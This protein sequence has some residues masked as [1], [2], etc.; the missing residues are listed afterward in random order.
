M[1]PLTVAGFA[2]VLA[3]CPT[4]EE[5]VRNLR[6]Q[7]D[8]VARGLDLAFFRYD[9]RRQ[10]VVERLKEVNGSVAHDPLELSLDHLPPKLK[11]EVLLGGSLV[12][13]G[14]QSA[15][16]LK[17]FGLGNSVEG[18]LLLQAVRFDGEPW[19]L[20]AV[21]EPRQR[22]GS[23]VA[24]RIGAPIGVF[25]LA[26]T[27]YAEREAR[28]HAEESLETLLG[29]VHEEYS[30]SLADLR[31]ALAQAQAHMTASGAGA[32]VAELERAARAAAEQ[33]RGAQARLAA[34]E[35]QVSA[36][37]TQLEKAH[38]DLS[39]QSD[40]LRANGAVFQEIEQALAGSAVGEDPRRMLEKVRA[41]VSAK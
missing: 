15:D 14:D 1:P 29:R 41:A 18:S 31:A 12:D 25:T 37:V 7:L 16:Y 24:E 32:R 3:R 39:R 20:L 9:A 2:H 40:L 19:G 33:A 6:V 27:Q 26:A 34:V 36:A 30:R 38:I 4:L 28:K 5:A 8:E 35:Q 13:F 21:R 11:R 17:F 10:L 23:R 22:F